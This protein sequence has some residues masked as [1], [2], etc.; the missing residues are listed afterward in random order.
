MTSPICCLVEA[1]ISA[2]HS[3]ESSSGTAAPA[4]PPYATRLSY[5][6]TPSCVQIT[7]TPGAISPERCSVQLAMAVSRVLASFNKE[8]AESIRQ[9]P[10]PSRDG[11]NFFLTNVRLLCQWDTAIKAAFKE[12]FNLVI[13]NMTRIYRDT[14]RMLENSDD[15]YLYSD[16]QYRIAEGYRNSPDLR[17]TWL[18]NIEAFH[19]NEQNFAEVAMCRVHMCALI[20]EYLFTTNYSQGL[21]SGAS[22]F[23]SVSPN[24]NDESA[25]HS[26]FEN[27]EGLSCSSE[28]SEQ[29]F[30]VLLESC[31]SALQKADLYELVLK[32]GK[33]HIAL[34]EKDRMYE[35][36]K[37][38]YLAM[39][40]TT[41]SVISA[42]KDKRLLGTYFRVRFRGPAF[43]EMSE[44]EFIYKE[45]KIT[46]LA[47]ITLRLEKFY[48]NKLGTSAF[49][50]YQEANELESAKLDLKK[51][52]I[53][54]THVQPYFDEIEDR[55]RMGEFERSIHLKQFVYDAPFTPG[56]KAHGLLHEQ[57][58]RRTIMQTS[59]YFPY[60]K[61]RI[62]VVSRE[63]FDLEPLAVALEEI[64]K[65]C[66]E[67]S[68][69]TTTFPV[70]IKLLQLVLQGTVSVS[71]NAGPMAIAKT[72]LGNEL[73]IN[74]DPQKQRKLRRLFKNL[75][76]YCQTAV[77]LNF[78]NSPADQALYSQDLAIKF[79][80]LKEALS[81]YIE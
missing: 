17:L 45:P 34:L 75:V 10:C 52:Y 39:A 44:K 11:V 22:A 19:Q 2:F 35:W 59:H 29:G 78:Q 55:N 20:S 70:N 16:M 7:S 31:R 63:S 81:P 32:I 27:E 46:P 73:K 79:Q 18:Q 69:V 80:S 14:I 30:S 12:K 1:W 26:S 54:I 8:S 71:V 53:Q 72:F 50:I 48:K 60:L 77:Q 66:N 33:I 51:N 49:E 24:V 13:D 41:D 9:S 42:N 38:V 47:D 76:S 40:D 58:K 4:Y 25:V 67:L 36:M 61:R 56:G 5:A 65:K 43:T 68:A 57:Y 74:Y 6:Y 62:T 23:Y 3:A 15:P 37:V 28:F 21:P 64:Q